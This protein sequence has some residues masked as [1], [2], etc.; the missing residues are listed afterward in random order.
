MLTKYVRRD[1]RREG[2]K[3]LKRRYYLNILIVFVVSVIL[4]G[5]YRLSTKRFEMPIDSTLSTAKSVVENNGNLENLEDL[6][7][8]RES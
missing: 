5:G 1:I 4:N 7:K 8:V 3:N 2:L 6:E